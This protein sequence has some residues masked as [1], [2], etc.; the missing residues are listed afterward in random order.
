MKIYYNR[1][2]ESHRFAHEL[3]EKGLREILREYRIYSSDIS[4]SEIETLLSLANR[5]YR[6][7]HG[8]E[9][10]VKYGYEKDSIIMYYEVDNNKIYCQSMNIKK[11]IAEELKGISEELLN[12]LRVLLMRE[13]VGE[14]DEYIM[15]I[16]YDNEE[17]SLDE[18]LKRLKIYDKLNSYEINEIAKALVKCENSYDDDNITNNGWYYVTRGYGDYEYEVSGIIEYET[19]ICGIDNCIYIDYFVTGD[20]GEE[21]T[22]EWT[23]LKR[24]TFDMLI[25]EEI[26]FLEK[27]LYK[28]TNDATNRR[29]KYKLNILREVLEIYYKETRKQEKLLNLEKEL[30]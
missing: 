30:A 12:K 21:L 28:S 26:N 10:Q 2:L 9:H 6:D 8:E 13:T 24:L 20:D 25:K 7:R 3:D 5:T 14:Y 22:S 4:D 16:D 15:E 29:D 27:S 17:I 19:H 11:F 18:L 1:D 23:F